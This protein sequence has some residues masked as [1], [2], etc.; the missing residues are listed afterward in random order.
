MRNYA[1]HMALS[2]QKKSLPLAP[3]QKR[4]LAR[5]IRDLN[6]ALELGRHGTARNISLPA[7]LK[8]ARRRFPTL[9]HT[10]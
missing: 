9:S 8:E 6:A 1:T 3:A 7:F 5:V 10:A 2:L 4:E